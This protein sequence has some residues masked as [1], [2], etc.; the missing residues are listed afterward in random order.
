MSAA[1]A[2]VNLVVIGASGR[3]GGS[4]LRLLP[5]FPGLQL[6]AAVAGPGSAS[7]GRDSGELAGAPPN[8]VTI[9]ASL[10][11]ALPGAALVLD[12]STAAGAAAR[13]EACSVAGLPLLLGATGLDPETA[14][15]LER[16]AGRIPLMVAPNTSPG[17]TV[18]HN[19]VRQA[20]AALGD[21]YQVSILDIHHRAKRDA[22]S[23]TALEL[24]AAVRQGGGDARQA[25]YASLRGGD[26]VG[27][28]DVLFLGE[29]ESLRLSHIATNRSVFAKGA[30]QAGLWLTRQAPGRYHMADMIGEK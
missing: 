27:Q 4:L 30:L 28:H 7:L 23:G 3:M 24:G 17:A 21:G 25:D 22:P 26:A 11:A 1:T 19:L 15:I 5:R 13:V 6:H 29:G 2:P 9:T 10:E 14:A 18:L 8:G 16:A 20:A 12:F